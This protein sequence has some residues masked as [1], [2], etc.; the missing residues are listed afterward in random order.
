[1]PIFVSLS[2]PESAEFIAPH[3]S[4]LVSLAVQL[5]DTKFNLN[6]VAEHLRHPIPTLHTFRVSA[7]TLG[8]Q[9]VA[10]SSYILDPFF[11]H[12][13]KLDLDGVFSFARRPKVPNPLVTFPHVTEL[14]VQNDWHTFVDIDHFLETLEQLPMLEKVSI[15]FAWW[16]WYGLTPTVTLP[17][18]REMSVFAPKLDE[19]VPPILMLIK[20]PNLTSL[21]L[22]IPLSESTSPYPILPTTSFDEYLPN[23]TNIPDLQA[24]MD[25]TSI[26]VAFR[27]PQAVFSYVAA[28]GFRTYHRDRSIWGALPLH[29]VRR[30]IVDVR[31][32]SEEVDDGWF[33]NM[34]QDLPNLERVTFRGGFPAVVQRLRCEVV[35]GELSIPIRTLVECAAGEY[36]TRDVQPLAWTWPQPTL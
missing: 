30:L 12:S 20:L 36:E 1:M 16:R 27:N 6:Q 4:R 7:G 24:T 2:T 28:D 23:L 19:T 10:L 26:E 11:I 15:T 29:T 22:Q 34:L 18:V 5:D 14:T 35:R 21:H 31:A 9:R 33:V 13:R 25:E 17:R 32:S 8:L 3:T